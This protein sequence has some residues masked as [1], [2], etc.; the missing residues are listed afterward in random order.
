MAP[1]I[2]TPTPSPYSYLQP[3]TLFHNQ[4]V[5]DLNTALSIDVMSHICRDAVKNVPVFARKG[6]QFISSIVQV[7]SFHG[8][9]VAYSPLH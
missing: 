8:E 4:V 9:G 6:N 5:S 2:P 1:P 7:L 3:P